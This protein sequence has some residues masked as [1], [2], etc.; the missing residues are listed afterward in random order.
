MNAA[1]LVIDD[2]SA[3]LDLMVYLLRAFR[4]EAIAAADG[5]QGVTLA[6]QARPAA[7]LC[8]VQMPRLDGF[9]VLRILKADPLTRAIPVIAV[10]ALA[11]VGDRERIMAA[12]FDGYITKPIVPETFVSQVEQYMAGEIRAGGG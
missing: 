9:E 5:E 8:D 4:H 6:R 3:N 2:N 11:M 12:G 10:T 7:I 1:V